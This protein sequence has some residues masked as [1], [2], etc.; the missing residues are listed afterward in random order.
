MRNWGPLLPLPLP[1][2]TYT[3][4]QFFPFFVAILYDLTYSLG[5][6]RSHSDTDLYILVS[7]SCDFLHHLF[8]QTIID[9]K[10][11]RSQIQKAIH[12]VKVGYT[13]KSE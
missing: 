8:F 4:L 10:R 6:S 9:I 7:R 5:P 1:F 13:E 12:L 2:L 3:R 11:Q